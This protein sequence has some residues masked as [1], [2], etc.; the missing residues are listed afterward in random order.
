MNA[1]VIEAMLLIVKWAEMKEFCDKHEGCQDCPYDL[2]KS[3]DI[4]STDYVLKES[5][6]VFRRY[7]E[8][9]GK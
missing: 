8:S 1:K 3:C 2:V 6:K 7:I 5:A 9:E 4:V